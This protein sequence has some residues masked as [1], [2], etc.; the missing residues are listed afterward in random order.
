MLKKIQKNGISPKITFSDFFLSFVMLWFVESRWQGS[1][2][3]CQCS[4]SNQG[5]LWFKNSNRALW[6][7][8]WTLSST[9]GRWRCL[10]Y[11]TF[12][13]SVIK[14]FCNQSLRTLRTHS[15]KVCNLHK[16]EDMHN[17]RFHMIQLFSN[18][19]S[20]TRFYMISYVIED[21]EYICCITY[22]LF[23]CT[24]STYSKNIVVKR[25]R[26]IMFCPSKQNVK[27]WNFVI[28]SE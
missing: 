27:K 21:F 17:H 11:Y 7:I 18:W 5:I 3:T 19:N 8:G 24:Y 20:L 2:V 13:F 12:F 23:V 14:K 22:F 25:L 28:T 1:V 16:L 9:L 10:E 15:S 4:L 26:D 6:A